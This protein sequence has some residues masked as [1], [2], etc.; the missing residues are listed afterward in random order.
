MRLAL[1]PL[2]ST[3]VDPGIDHAAFVNMTISNPT[4]VSSSARCRLAT[5][6]D[7]IL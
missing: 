6:V 2:S 4:Q 7:G 3:S 1:E 5:E